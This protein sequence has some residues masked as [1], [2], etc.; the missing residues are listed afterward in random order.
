MADPFAQY[1]VKRQPADEEDPFAEF[2]NPGAPVPAPKRGWSAGDIARGAGDLAIGFGKGALH[3]AIDVGRIAAD[4]GMLPGVNRFSLPSEV[5]EHAREATGY[6]NNTQRVG[7]AAE[8]V[9]EMLIPVTK[10]AAAAN[11]AIPRAARASAKFQ[12]V[13]GAARNIPIDVNAPG[14][15]A[16]RI[17]ELADR[18]GSMPMAVRKFLAHVTDPAKPEMTYEIARDFAS[19]ISR[20]SADEFG[21]LTPAVAREVAGLRVALNKS[22]GEAA[23]RAGK[24]REYIE[25]M[26]EYLRA[27]KLEEAVHS[28]WLKAKSGIPYVGGGGAGYWL[29]KKIADLF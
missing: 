8:T 28:A 22:V 2:A 15:V 26:N 10:G 25:A 17:A 3:T 24:G 19:N 11:A 13:M 21:R 14:A 20:L 6:T 12:E 4:S 23:A 1:A 5:T 7:G 9:A 27:K 16:L 18:G 29:T